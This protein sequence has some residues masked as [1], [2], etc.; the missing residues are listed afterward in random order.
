MLVGRGPGRSDRH[1]GDAPDAPI[2]RTGSAPNLRAESIGKACQVPIL[3]LI[4]IPG[5]RPVGLLSRD[6]ANIKNRPSWAN[7]SGAQ[8][9]VAAQNPAGGRNAG[10]GPSQV[11]GSS[12]VKQ[13]NPVAGPPHRL[14]SVVPNRTNRPGDDL[15]MNGSLACGSQTDAGSR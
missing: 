5:G 3:F 9:W 1:P 15:R 14:V 11:S 8:N 12:L 6:V 7:T 13:S 2:R 4:D 10:V